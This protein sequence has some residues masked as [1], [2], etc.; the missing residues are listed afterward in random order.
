M[1]V[2]QE[3]RHA[4]RYKAAVVLRASYE[5]REPE[6]LR[7]E[8]AITN[9]SVVGVALQHGEA[10]G[11]GMLAAC[12]ELSLRLGYADERFDVTLA[13]VPRKRRGLACRLVLRETYG[14]PPSR[15]G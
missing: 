3:K 11:Q 9:F 15:A 14:K 12:G 13:R 7:I 4:L 1:L 8:G 10:F 6:P 5:W 2:A